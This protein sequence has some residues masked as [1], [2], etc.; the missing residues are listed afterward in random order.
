M[1]PSIS[2][3]FSILK[4]ANS[5]NQADQNE[6]NKNKSKEKVIFITKKEFFEPITDEYVNSISK[7][8]PEEIYDNYNP[9]PT[10]PDG[11]VNFEC[12]CVSHI[13]A[14]PCGYDFRKAMTCQKSAS[15]K[16]LEEG[17]CGEEFMKFLEC[18]MSTGCFRRTPE[19][20]LN[21]KKDID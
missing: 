9:G 21:S 12:H 16:E 18:V 4:I 8:S 19:E 11:S 14:S 2:K 7:M 10:N 6:E 5:H 20:E 3:F 13:V 17:A 1:L 15:E